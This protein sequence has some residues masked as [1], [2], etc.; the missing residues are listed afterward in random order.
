MSVKS[1]HY[2]TWTRVRLNDGESMCVCSAVAI[3]SPLDTAFLSSK[4][5][6]RCEFSQEAFIDLSGWVQGPSLDSV[7]LSQ[8]KD[9]GFSPSDLQLGSLTHLCGPKSG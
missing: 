9:M 2:S 7:S 6:L 1:H 4:T 8:Y 3:S 5:Q